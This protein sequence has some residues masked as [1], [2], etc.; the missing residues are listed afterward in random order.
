MKILIRSSK[1]SSKSVF[2]C[3]HANLTLPAPPSR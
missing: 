3:L 2:A 1:R